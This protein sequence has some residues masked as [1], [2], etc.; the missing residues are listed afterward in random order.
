M[1]SYGV[2]GTVS[3]SSLQPLLDERNKLKAEVE[4]LK[5]ENALLREALATRDE[6]IKELTE[7]LDNMTFEWDNS[8]TEVA[9]EVVRA[10]SAER[11]C[12]EQMAHAKAEW[13]RVK[14]LQIA[15]ERERDEVR[16]LLED[17]LNQAC[18]DSNGYVDTSAL[19]AYEDAAVWLEKH[20]RLVKAT[21]MTNGREYRWVKP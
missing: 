10:E 7:S 3:N 16:E 11:H 8:R 2:T 4:H 21:E 12:V 1:V 9:V 14:D 19:S 15:E 17:V 6:M 13:E 20:G 5:A 18:G